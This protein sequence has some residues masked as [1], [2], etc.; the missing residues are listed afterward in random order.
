MA[1]GGGAGVR[2]VHRHQRTLDLQAGE[3]GG[4]LGGLGGALGNADLGERHRGLALAAVDQRGEQ[5]QPPVVGPGTV[6]VLAVQRDLPSALVAGGA[7]PQPVADD[8]YSEQVLGEV[9][10]RRSHL[11]VVAGPAQCG[12]HRRRQDRHQPV[13]DPPRLA[14]IGQALQAIQ[15]RRD[16]SSMRN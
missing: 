14:R 10:G 12:H 1:G 7:V 13:P 4:D 2:G 11:P 16:R 3:Q 9:R 6:Q 15:Q 8:A 5:H